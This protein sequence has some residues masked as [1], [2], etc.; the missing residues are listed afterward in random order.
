MI[1]VD[2]CIGFIILRA[3]E[4]LAMR[5]G[6]D[7]F[8][9]LEAILEVI[10]VQSCI[11]PKA[12]KQDPSS[13]RKR[14]QV[15]KWQPRSVQA[16]GIAH[17]YMDRGLFASDSLRNTKSTTNLD[18]SVNFMHIILPSP[19]LKQRVLILLLSLGFPSKPRMQ[20]RFVDA[21]IFA[22]TTPHESGDLLQIWASVMK[23]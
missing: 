9:L 6:L 13:A 4:Q 18:Y 19:K 17:T 10:R 1:C 23:S 2:T 21:C 16:R 12:F 20:P 5:T 14:R 11:L 3:P 8:G 15:C 7:D 22:V